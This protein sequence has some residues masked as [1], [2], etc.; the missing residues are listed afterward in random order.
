LHTTEYGYRR[1]GLSTKRN[2]TQRSREASNYCRNSRTTAPKVCDRIE[3]STLRE[4]RKRMKRLIG[5]LAAGL[6]VVAAPLAAQDAAVG[7][8]I[9]DTKCSVCHNTDSAD[10]KIGP[11]LAGIKEGKLPSGKDATTENMMENLNKGGNG[12]PA[13]E[14]LLSDEEKADIVAYVKTL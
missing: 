6:M 7:Q 1:S 9:F 10:K 8:E 2:V 11:G 13:F 12:M 5:L 3:N 4:D 14:K